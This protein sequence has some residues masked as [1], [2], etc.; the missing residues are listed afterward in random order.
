MAHSGT[1]LLMAGAAVALA[2]AGTAAVRAT[3]RPGAPRPRLGGIAIGLATLLPLGVA[4]WV[5]GSAWEGLPTDPVRLAC[6]GLSALVILC[7]GVVDDLVGTS[8]AQKLAVQCAIALVVYAVGVRIGKVTL[9]GS[10][11]VPLSPL[12]GLVVTVAWIVVVTN[13][14][15]LLDG[16]DGLAA[17]VSLV[18]VVTFFA[19]GW[20]D[21]D[22]LACAVSATL[23]GAL[24]GFLFFN[25][26]PGSVLMG[27]GGSLFVGFVLATVGIASAQKQ[28]AAWALTGPAIA[29]GLPLFDTGLAIVRRLHAGRPVMR[30]DQEHVHHRLVAM[31]YSRRGAVFLLWGV[32]LVLA[33]SAGALR[34][35]GSPRLAGTIAALG[36]GAL[37]AVHARHRAR[38]VP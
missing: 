2:M 29:L 30:G 5:S 13:A 20:A 25:F 33:G 3:R 14:V 4:L 34:L 24:V 12:A 37:A 7:L 6:L 38:G 36:L 26:A 11:T 23:A 21:G 28:A 16:L 35:G 9:P 31:G 8:P 18:A 32:A 22:L 17:G 27:D 15:N 1:L 10:G 19:F